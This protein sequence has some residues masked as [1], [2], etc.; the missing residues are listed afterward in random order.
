MVTIT[1][2]ENPN[3]NINNDN[4][5]NN[6]HKRD[7]SHNSDN[8]NNGENSDNGD[9]S[10]RND[11]NGGDNSDEICGTPMMANGSNNT[12]QSGA[13]SPGTHHPAACPRRSSGVIDYGE[14]AWEELCCL[15]I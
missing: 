15:Y 4:N 13:I 12:R 14:V 8:S 11:N 3:D 1:L 10:T 6:R 9:S 2:N 5:Y 7:T